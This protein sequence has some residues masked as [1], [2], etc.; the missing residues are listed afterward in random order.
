VIEVNPHPGLD[1]HYDVYPDDKKDELIS[2]IVD[3]AFM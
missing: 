2:T 3:N 1:I